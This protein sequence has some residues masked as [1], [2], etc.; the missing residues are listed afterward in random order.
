MSDALSTT[1]QAAAGSWEEELSL[2]RRRVEALRASGPMPDP[3]RRADGEASFARLRAAARALFAATIA[4]YQG[5]CPAGYPAVD[6]NEIS[7]TGGA[8]GIRFSE[9]HSFFFALE[10]VVVRQKKDTV[11][12]LRRRQAAQTEPPRKRM[13]GDPIPPPDPNEPVRLAMIALRFDE[14]SG[15]AEVHRTL[16]PRWDE[17]LLREHL[18]AYL[19]GVGYDVTVSAVGT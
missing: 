18:A 8:V 5:F 13:P 17:L 12:E 7:G 3:L 2:L 15:W 10:R 4:A 9:H 14:R 6:D 19:V 11:E 1:L 16:D